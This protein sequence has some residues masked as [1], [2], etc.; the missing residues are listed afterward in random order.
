MQNRHL[1]AEKASHG[2]EWGYTSTMLGDPIGFPRSDKRTRRNDDLRLWTDSDLR[3]PQ[4]L[5]K[6]VSTVSSTC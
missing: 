1:T 5:D 3:F 4:S 2:G 6:S